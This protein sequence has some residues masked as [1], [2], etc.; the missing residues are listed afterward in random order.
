MF[1]CLHDFGPEQG[2]NIKAERKVLVYKAALT[3]Q[4]GKKGVQSISLFTSVAARMLQFF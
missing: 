1:H 3:W 4:P 2:Q